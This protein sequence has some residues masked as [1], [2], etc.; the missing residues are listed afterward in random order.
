MGKAPW[1][2][3]LGGG[4]F[5]IDVCQAPAFMWR[6]GHDRRS[7]RLECK[8]QASVV[9]W[10]SCDV[11]RSGRP[12]SPW[13]PRH[14]NPQSYLHF[15]RCACLVQ[16]YESKIPHEHC[17]AGLGTT[18]VL[19]PGLHLYVALQKRSMQNSVVATEGGSHVHN[20]CMHS[21]LSNWHA[22]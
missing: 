12:D 8:W 18:C 11:G 10:W 13:C 9:E 14:H 3:H 1:R 16:N 2:Y 17:Q 6:S 21:L 19:C 15:S 4:V 20:L 22:I 5:K 7:C